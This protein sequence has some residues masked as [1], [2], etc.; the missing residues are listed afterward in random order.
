MPESKV[1]AT[2]LMRTED[3]NISTAKK[4]EG[5]RA[6]TSETAEGTV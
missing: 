4:I 2:V 3:H 5:Y 1:T 6:I